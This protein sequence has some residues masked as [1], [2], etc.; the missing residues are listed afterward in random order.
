ME[1][2]ES[3][4]IAETFCSYHKLM[5]GVAETGIMPRPLMIANT[6]LACDANQ[7]SFPRLAKFYDV[8]H[9]VIDVPTTADEDAVV[10]VADQLRELVS[11]LED[12]T[13]R[14]LDPEALRVT[15][16]NS[17]RTIQAYQRSLALRGKV[18]L[19]TTMTSELCAMISTHIM[20]GRPEALRFMEDVLAVTERARGT[21]RSDKVRLF[22][23][24]TLPNWQESMR[25]I[26]DAGPECELVGTDIAAESID[27][28]DPDHPFESMA[29]RLVYGAM[30]GRA[31]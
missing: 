28:P 31:K 14:S 3:H 4:D 25:D 13:H 12:A 21:E 16:M 2:S 30:N 10:Y 20:L 15:M 6:T 11:L 29:R 27:L 23:I 17:R 1:T 26:F 19:D 18:S 8:P 22:W 7:L 24:H 9:Y 5:I